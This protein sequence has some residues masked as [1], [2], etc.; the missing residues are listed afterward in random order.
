MLRQHQ[1]TRQKKQDPREREIVTQ[2]HPQFIAPR[3]TCHPSAGLAKFI[4]SSTV[5]AYTVI[6]TGV[7]VLRFSLVHQ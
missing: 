6:S 4:Y 5:F 7:L 3:C 1:P 2:S